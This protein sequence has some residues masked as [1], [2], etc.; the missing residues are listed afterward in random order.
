[1]ARIL[2]FPFAAGPTLAHVASCLAVGERLRARGH[3]LTVAHSG[4][5]TELIEST[6][7]PVVRATPLADWR[8]IAGK[9]S[10]IYTSVDELVDHAR[11]DQALIERIAPDAIVVD[12]RV[13]ALLAA[14]VTGVPTVSIQHFLRVSAFRRMPLG[15]RLWENRQPTRLVEALRRSLPSDHDG[16]RRLT[17]DF[18]DARRRLGL[19]PPKQRADA[20]AVACTT[21]PLFDPTVG[22]PPHWS[23]VGPI[24]WS[25]PAVD[26]RPVERGSRPLVYVTQ[27]SS[28][29][30]DVL[31]RAVREL[32]REPVDV[33]VTTG[34]FLDPRDLES[35][36]PNVRSERMLPGR[37]CLEAADVAVVHGGHL[38]TSQAHAVGTPV[39]VLPTKYDQWA[40]SERVVR[41]GTG[42]VLARPL[43]P[44]AIGRAVRKVLADDRYA[45]AA[46]EI[47]QHLAAWDGAQH[48]ADLAERIAGRA[49]APAAVSA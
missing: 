42:V 6:G 45:R 35:L 22:L 30:E 11:D 5:L 37:E 7:L 3:E 15:Q 17:A 31:R 38:T 1:M 49:V 13:S 43:L 20:T 26:T 27:G 12:Y 28:G 14:A 25:A 16:A 39:V 9:V 44:G 10:R 48:T 29:S 32:A 19:P 24:T 33:L 36:A 21:T 18:R 34:P 40:W 2:L 41:F 8:R 4:D 47:A 46:G 23:Y